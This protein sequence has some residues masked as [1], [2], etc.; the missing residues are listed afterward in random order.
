[1]KKKLFGG[2]A[3]LALALAAVAAHA[4]GFPS[5]PLRFVVPFPPGGNLDVTTRLIADSMAKTL[6]QSIVID[7]RSGA[8]GALGSEIVAKAAPDGYTIVAATTATTIVSPMLVPNPPYQLSSFAPVGVMA[9]TPLLVEVPVASPHADLKDFLAYARANPGKLTIGHSGNGTTN[10]IAILQLQDAAKISL[11]PIPY[12]GSGPA[13]IDLIGAQIE[14]A[15]DQTSGS[16][17]HIRSGKLRP[18]A[19]TTSARVADLPNVPTLIEQ[20]LNLEIATPSLLLAP[21]R[22]PPDVLKAL[23]AALDKALADP[24]IVKKLADLGSTVRPMT[25]EQTDRFLKDEE[26]KMKALAATGVLK[27]N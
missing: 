24:T 3:G 1:M 16:L 26:A 11:N 21:A 6:G 5:K 12:K 23:N 22:T 18:L 17:P 10:H 15:I 20:G 14:A 13:I 7:N 4:Q 25:V 8:G 9:I 27:G 2:I 19:V